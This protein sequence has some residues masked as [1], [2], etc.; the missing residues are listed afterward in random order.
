MPLVSGNRLGPY[1]VVELLGSGGMGE[2]YRARD[3]RL[4][5]DVALKVLHE[6]VAS[7]PARLKRFELEARAV[8]ALN[9]PSILSVY[10]VGTQRADEGSGGTS[11]AVP[12]VVTELLEG[13][14]LREVLSRRSATRHQVLAWAVQTAQGLAAAHHKGIVHRDLKPENLF[15]TT[16]GRIKIL[17]FGLAKPT[18]AGPSSDDSAPTTLSAHT[19]PGTVMGTVGYMS[20]EQIKGLPVDHR[21]DI[22]SFGV[23]FYEMLAHRHPFRRETMAATF[24]SILH[25]EPPR[26]ASVDRTLPP[27]LDGIVRRCLE[28]RREERFQGAHDLALALEAV[29]QAPTG[30][31][32]LQQVEERSPYPGLLSF[33]EKDAAVF[34]GR[35]SEVT[36]LWGRIRTRRLL[37]VIGPSGVGKTSFLRAGVL[38]ARPE[39][40]GAVHAIPGANPGLGLAR[41]LTP[42]LA[43]DTEAMEDLLSGV[44]ELTGAGETER[45]V[46]AVRRWRA[47]R[48]EALVVVDQFEELFTLNAGE[49][50]QRFAALIGRL[51]SEADV[52]VVLSL[53]DDFLIRCSDQSPLA[54]VFSEITPLTALTR[55]GLERALV[56]PAKKQGYRFDDDTLVGEMVSRVEGV[57]GA[58]PLLAFA[59]ARLWEKRDR[60]RK[61]LTREAYQ[62]IGGVEG[63]LAQHAEATMDRIGPERQAVVREIFRNLVTAQGTRVGIDREEL[64]SAFPD[65]TGADDV[66]RQ[67][68]DAR[69]LTTYEVE[70][71]EGEP[72]HHRVEVVHE[73][74]LKGWPRLVRWQAQDEEGA[75]LR[76]QLKQAAHL[77]EE[78]GRTSDLLWTGT[79]Y[80]EFELWRGRYP[81]TLTALEEGFAKAMAERARRRTRVRRLVVGSVLAAAVSVAGVTGALWRRSEASRERAAAEARRAEASKLLALAQLK[82]Q[83]DP[84]EALAFTTASLELADA[85]EARVMALRALQEAPP[86]WEVPLEIGGAKIPAFS[87][88]GRRLAVA[89]HSSVVGVWDEN[90]GPPVRLPGNDTSPRGG[91]MALWASNELLVTGLHGAKVAQP[92]SVLRTGHKVHVWSLPGGTKLRTIDFGAPSF[93]QVGPGRLFAETPEG[94]SVESSVGGGLL[95]SWRLPDGEPEVLGR[96]GAQK[97]GITSSVFEPHGRGWLYT[98]G[99]TTHFV[100]LPVGR[101][102]HR[103]SSRHPADVILF[104]LSLRPEL[105]LAQYDTTGENRLLLFPENGPP[106][107]TILPKPGSAPGRVFCTS[108]DRWLGNVPNEDGKLRLWDTAALP[109][110][111]PLELRREGSWYQAFSALHPADR[112][113]VT[114]THDQSRL[115]FW[116][117]PSRWPSA[118]DGYKA[119]VRP[120][121]FSPDGKWLATTW[122]DRRLRLWPLPRTGPTE[123]RRLD[124]PAVMLWTSLAFDPGGRYLFAVGSEDNAWIV[125]LDGSPARQLEAFSKDTLLY[126]AAVSPSGR[127]LATAFGLGRG[128]KTLRIWDVDT[129]HLRLLD[130]PEPDRPPSPPAGEAKP[131]AIMDAGVISL[132]FA[133]DTILYT[134]GDGGLRR[135]NLEPGSHELVSPV[136]PSRLASAWMVD[137]RRQALVRPGARGGAGADCI[138]LELVDLATGKSQ[139]IPEYGCANWSAAD[140][141]PGGTVASGSLDGTVRVGR[142]G[143]GQPHALV[144]HAGKV[145]LVAISPDLRWIASTGEDNTLRLWPMPDLDKPP[146]HTLPHDELVVRLKSLTNLRAVRDPKSAT[147]WTVELGPFPGWKNI[148]AW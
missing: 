115:T 6:D 67:L 4:G 1:E 121:A 91:N 70:G 119:I 112:L 2:V 55:D 124:T 90:G 79:A 113:V 7:D 104:N 59:V 32:F 147:G 41:A 118:V 68:I 45:V 63:S 92:M 53:R 120:V 135:W 46:S 128:P 82:L 58:L 143:G 23:V 39:G 127:R 146:L 94:T 52:H 49:T 95:R 18:T 136:A 107:T 139:P 47:R 60:E 77:W 48:A 85:K 8:A 9:H 83:E 38:P 130:L 87:P 44:A 61:L 140:T 22:F 102:G 25:G 122:T 93:W 29:L 84:T 33:T 142:L 71:K 145:D 110:A 34:F 123:V 36:A 134:G 100:P 10:D 109:D 65:R 3:P 106:V 81:G 42:D 148:P 126:G 12:Y 15:L 137:D 96:I 66:L 20:P 99:T 141:G 50:Q 26:L 13:E 74:L 14:T 125:P 97:L 11:A 73:S 31:T 103:L 105:L 138:P 69:L 75:V 62:E 35:E 21:S 98:R 30:A 89:G 101:E 132:A 131:P 116:P 24:N 28:K 64:L 56:E 54:P 129:G 144:G 16:D 111:R 40:W 88:D 117:L 72:G 80:Q 108:S 5:R 19:E 37:A 51:A 27:A 57:R 114:T 133:S 43:G 17:D 86:A 76:D 78:K